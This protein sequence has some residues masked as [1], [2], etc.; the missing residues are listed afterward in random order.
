MNS[1]KEPPDTGDHVPEPSETS[2]RAKR[3]ADIASRTVVKM[4]DYEHIEAHKARDLLPR[5]IW[6]DILREGCLAILGGE[7]KAKKSWFALGLCMHAVC[8][9]PF[10]GIRMEGKV[11]QR[12]AIVLDFELLKGNIMSRFVALAEAFADDPVEWRAIWDNVE[13]RAHRGM[14][15]EDVPWI[16]YCAHVIRCSKQGD[17]VIVDCLQ[18]LPAGDANDPAAV[19]RVLGLL[20][21]AATQS[22]ACVVVVDHFNKSNEARGKNRLSGSVAKAATPDAILLLESDGR[23][24]ITFSTELRMDP[25]RDPL[26]LEFRSPS[27]GFRVVD[28]SERE[29][30]KDAAKDRKNA[31]LLAK[32]FPDIGR[33]YTKQEL[34]LNIGK[35]EKT[36]ENW[37]KG[38][39]GAF[40]IHH[41]SG[42]NP[43]Q[44]SRIVAG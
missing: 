11:R 13:I 35:S 2:E 28:Q 29:E 43:H 31:E 15:A 42:K 24:F 41:G 18:A 38:L 9:R 10:L 19:R 21:A 25:S 39:A 4:G 40:T 33:S 14:L 30:R 36:V 8:V 7:S 16:D 27:E 6:R 17:L 32:L 34:A 20:Q 5:S 26:T 1:W 37:L 3:F 22:G 23:D 44:Y 12:C